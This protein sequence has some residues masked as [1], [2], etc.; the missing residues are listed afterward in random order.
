MKKSKKNKKGRN[1]KKNNQRESKIYNYDESKDN[2]APS[3]NFSYDRNMNTEDNYAPAEDLYI[4]DF[5][6]YIKTVNEERKGKVK[7]ILNNF[8]IKYDKNN[9][10]SLKYMMKV[11][12]KHLRLNTIFKECFIVLEIKSY[13]LSAVSKQFYADDENNQRL[14]ISIYNFDKKF[15]QSDFRPGKF[16][17]IKEI[18]YKQ[19]LDGKIGIRVENPNNVIL[20]KNKEEVYNYITREIGDINEYLK[21]GD[22]YL[23]KH[24]YSSAMNI[25]L[26]CSELKIEDKLLIFQI[27]KRIINSCLKINAYSLSLQ[28][29]DKYLLFQDKNNIDIIKYKIRSLVNCRKFQE[30]KQFLIDNRNALQNEEYRN[31][32]KYIKS[33][34]DNI[35]GIFDFNNIKGSDVSDYFSSKIEIDLHDNKGNRLIAK[36]DISKGELL[37]VSKAFYLLTF[38]EY[39]QGLKEYYESI[40]YKRFRVYFFDELAESM[41]DPEFYLYENLDEQKKISEK[42]YEKLLDLDDFDNWN[43]KYSERAEK[44]PDK[45]NPNLLRV[46]EINS[47]KVHSSIFSCE[48]QGYGLGLWYYPSFI[49]HSCNPNTLEFGI[50]DIFI[51]YSQKEIKKGEEITRRYFPYGLDLPR[52][53][54]YLGNYGFVCKCE[55]CSPQLQRYFSDKEK[56]DTYINEYHNLYNEDIPNTELYISITNLENILNENRLEFNASDF[57]NFYFRAGLILLNRKIYYEMTENYFN[58]AYILIEGKNFHFECIILHYLYILYFENSV[59][60]KMKIIENKIDDKLT[61]FFGNNIFKSKLLDIYKER[62]NNELLKELNGKVKY[63]EDIEEEKK[64]RK[65]NYLNNISCDGF[66][67]TNIFI[68]L[69]LLCKFYTYITN[70]NN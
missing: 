37:I 7:I 27:Y 45:E 57:I 14:Y 26:C 51:L 3:I 61:N 31:Q 55:I 65:T 69:L 24:E 29:C 16:I 15:S 34:V 54:Q 35:N 59:N 20:F 63:F 53:H 49:N 67:I 50:N 28:Y 58:K 47:I 52:K 30:A 64:T 62:K 60:E 70:K 13:L 42:D 10:A 18:F 32:Q 9:S 48:N 5:N 66:L 44:H 46:V 12:K 33:N 19:F 2:A 56:Y 39:L 25:Y 41:V 22:S 11:D 8:N 17:I 6:K 40:N 23:A 38:E 4:N 43:V 68:F 21:R 1:S 36:E